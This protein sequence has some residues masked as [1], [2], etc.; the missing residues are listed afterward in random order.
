MNTA[1]SP[2]LAVLVALEWCTVDEATKIQTLLTHQ[3]IP[4]NVTDCLKQL[5]GAR[6]A[7][8]GH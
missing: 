1:L 3:E 2:F 4:F 5:E 7:V 8:R 6:E